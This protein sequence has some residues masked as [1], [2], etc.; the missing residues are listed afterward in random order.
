MKKSSPEKYTIDPSFQRSASNVNIEIFDQ[1]DLR[2][3]PSYRRPPDVSNTYTGHLSSFDPEDVH[4]LEKPYHRPKTCK[5]YS[6]HIPIS[7]LTKSAA[8]AESKD[9]EETAP[10]EEVKTSTMFRTFGKHLD[11][12][13]RYET[14]RQ[15]LFKRGQTQQMLMRIVQ[16]KLSERSNSYAQQQIWLR[17][18][19]ANF[20]QNGNS[21]L[22]EIEFRQCLELM[23]IQFDDCQFLALFAFLDKDQNGTIDFEEFANYAMIPNPKGGTA[24]LTKAITAPMQSESWKPLKINK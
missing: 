8:P 10:Y 4:D 3:S 9:H 1:P 13:E 2:R 15:D 5:G 23:N 12:L 16:A 7:K 19:F 21:G 18:L 6:G 14:A 22:D 11:T 20:D 17:N 24:V